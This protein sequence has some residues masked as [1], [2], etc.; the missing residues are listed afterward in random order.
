LRIQLS[1]RP[2]VELSLWQAWR[3]RRQGH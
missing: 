2:P 3:T 1:M